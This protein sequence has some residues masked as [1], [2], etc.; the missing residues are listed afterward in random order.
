MANRIPLIAGNWKM[1]KTNSEAVELVKRLKVLVKSIKAN[2]C[3][4]VVCPPFT[5]LS[6]VAKELKGT[7]IY[8]G[9]QNLHFEDSGAFTGEVSAQMLKEIGCK[10]V[11]IGHSERRQL[12][13]ETNAA[14]NKKIFAV[15]G[16]F[17][18]AKKSSIEISEIISKFK[19][20]G[21][22]ETSTR[23]RYKRAQVRH[24]ILA[25]VAVAGPG[26]P[27]ARCAVHIG[28]RSAHIADCAAKIVHPGDSLHL[29]QDGVQRPALDNPALVAGQGAEG[30]PAAA[31]PVAGD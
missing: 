17:H 7:N 19:K 12:F 13:G 10:Y 2:D 16:G 29:F 8:L 26:R 3:E 1:N 21:I 23:K 30:A 27:P 14:V 15:F 9:A 31:A 20:M 22:L 5:A 25:T 28:C 24:A 4:I 11:I 6:D 18:L